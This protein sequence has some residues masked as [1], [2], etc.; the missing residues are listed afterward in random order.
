[1]SNDK[2]WTT[3]SYRIVYKNYPTYSWGLYPSEWVYSNSSMMDAIETSL[4]AMEHFPD[5]EKIINKVKSG[6]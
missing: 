1:M 6:N 2:K 3:S 4:D 5:A